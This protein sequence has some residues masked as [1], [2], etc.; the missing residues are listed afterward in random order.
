MAHAPFILFFAVA[1]VADAMGTLSATPL[2]AWCAIAWVLWVL[3]APFSG[4]LP[5]LWG[6]AREVMSSHPFRCELQARMSD[7][8]E[9]PASLCRSGINSDAIHSPELPR[10]F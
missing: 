7:E 4:A 8:G 10:V 3:A 9:D 6:A 2:P 1:T 5:W